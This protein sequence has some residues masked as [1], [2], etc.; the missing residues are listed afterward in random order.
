LQHL[1]GKP[2]GKKGLEKT[3]LRLEEDINFGVKIS[4]ERV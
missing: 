1:D 3:W 4:D 2:E